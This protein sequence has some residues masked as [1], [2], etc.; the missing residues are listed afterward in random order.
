MLMRNA[1]SAY[2]SVNCIDDPAVYAWNE[3]V[4]FYSGTGSLSGARYVNDPDWFVEPR[5]KKAL[6]V[7]DASNT[8]W[9]IHEK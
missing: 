1:N 8:A 3:V 9:L 4:A 6:T 2:S 7:L 5:P